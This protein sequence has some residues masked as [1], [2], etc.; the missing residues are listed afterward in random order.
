MDF[1]FHLLRALLCEHVGVQAAVLAGRWCP[2]FGYEW[3]PIPTEETARPFKELGFA[4]WPPALRLAE[5]HPRRQQ[6][7]LPCVGGR[8]GLVELTEARCEG[9]QQGS[10]QPGRH[11]TYRP[12]W[13]PH[14]G[15]QAY[16]IELVPNLGRVLACVGVGAGGW[17]ARRGRRRSRSL[18]GWWPLRLLRWCWLRLAAEEENDLDMYGF[19]ARHAGIVRARFFEYASLGIAVEVR[20]WSRSSV[21]M[22]SYP[23]GQLVRSVDAPAPKS[24]TETAPCML[25]AFFRRH[26]LSSNVNWVRDRSRCRGE[27]P[28]HRHG[29]FYTRS[30]PYQWDVQA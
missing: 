27:V 12:G 25:Q 7:Q 17:L 21:A 15:L 18:R 20:P 19:Q 9:S 22:S 28:E 14:F 4:L 26:A 6:E 24:L 1:V 13:L 11:V 16:G 23:I 2:C 3:E 30:R 8:R 29:V 10:S 5:Q